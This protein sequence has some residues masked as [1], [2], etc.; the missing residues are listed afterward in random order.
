DAG[1]DRPVG[2]PHD[3]FGELEFGPAL[4]V[5]DAPVGADGAF[6]RPLPGLVEG[7][8]D[9]VHV[10]LLG[11]DVEE[12]SQEHALVGG[13]GDRIAAGAAVAGPADLADDDRLAGVEPLQLVDTVDGVVHAFV[14]VNALPVGQQMHGDVIHVLDELGIVLPDVGR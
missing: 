14:Q 6:G 10:I 2:D 3:G 1:Q 8:H 7:L 11:R 5:V 4:D 12:A 9:V 13:R